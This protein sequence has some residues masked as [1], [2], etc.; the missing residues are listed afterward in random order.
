[1]SVI[2][3][4]LDET[5]QK[6]KD[7]MDIENGYLSVM[8][9]ASRQYGF[10]NITELA[11]YVRTHSL[12]DIQSK[13]NIGD[14]FDILWTDNYASP[15][16]SVT[17]T[18]TV[19][20]I[21][22][23]KKSNGNVVPGVILFPNKTVKALGKQYQGSYYTVPYVQKTFLLTNLPALSN[24]DIIQFKY[25]TKTATPDTSVTRYITVN[26]N[27]SAGGALAAQNNNPLS[28]KMDF[29]ASDTD[30]NYNARF[31]ITNGTHASPTYEYDV[32]LNET[33]DV[34]SVHVNSYVGGCVPVTWDGNLY[35]EFY[36]SSCTDG[37]WLNRR[38][39]DV[40]LSNTYKTVL[41]YGFMYGF[42]SDFLAAI[43]EIEVEENVLGGV[44]RK[45]NNYFFP[46]SNT[47]LYYEPANEKEGTAWQ[48]FVEGS[49]SASPLALGTASEIV[50]APAVTDRVPAGF[51]ASTY[52]VVTRSWTGTPSGSPKPYVIQMSNEYIHGGISAV[53]SYTLSNALSFH[54][55]CCIC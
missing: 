19:V 33:H 31:T 10:K 47:N 50:F 29:Y 13:V 41:K 24:G 54:P 42:P 45:S 14:S 20:D 1:M 46:P 25:H 2:P 9:I 17:I 30:Q 44:Y 22:N 23:V 43:G 34:G 7:Q 26:A 36:N 40:A 6:L 48:Y 12:S 21:K 4:V 8:A 35:R 39:F 11:N 49:G 32:Y 51:D 27:K 5:L 18:Y 28:G 37:S 52:G 55:C 15:P 3:T 38:T 16:S 53:S